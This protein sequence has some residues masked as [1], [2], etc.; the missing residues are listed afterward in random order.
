MFFSHKVLRWF[1]P[2]LLLTLLTLSVYQQWTT[3]S[4]LRLR[5][6]G[7]AT[8][9]FLPI[10]QSTNQLIIGGFAVL[11]LCA[12]LGRLFRASRAAI[13]RPFKLCDHFVTMQ[14]ALFVGFL[15]FCRGNL[16]GS[17]E[18]TPRGKQSQDD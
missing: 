7:F 14:A 9:D 11:L 6:Y 10:I 18:R 15:R 13:A 16:K 5:D 17:W 1:T 2:H 4:R 8:T 12:L 3:A